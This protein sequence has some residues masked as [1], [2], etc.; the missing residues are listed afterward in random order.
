MQPNLS[1]PQWSIHSDCGSKLKRTGFESRLCRM[2]AIEVAHI[3]CS[4]LFKGMERAVLSTM[5][6]C[7]IK[8]PWSYMI[9][10]GHSADFGFPS[11]VILP[12]LCRK[13]CKVIFTHT[14]YVCNVC[15]SPDCRIL[16]PW[17][18]KCPRGEI[19]TKCLT[20]PLTLWRLS[21]TIVVINLY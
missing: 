2:F 3:V 11:V 15:I 10:V 6:L 13:R 12:W 18:Y 7:I 4:K 9:T 5:V 1:Q 19:H 8:N 21:T 17:D 16:N 20:L 14:V